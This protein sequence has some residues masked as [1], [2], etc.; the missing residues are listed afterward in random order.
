MV[1]CWTSFL[2]DGSNQ[3]TDNYGGTLKNRARLPLAVA[4]EVARVWG[5]KRVGYKIS[6]HFL[7]HAMSDTN[8]RETFAYLAQ[9]LGRLGIGYI[10]LVEPIGGR[11]GQIQP[12]MQM[13]PLI[14]KKFDGT[15]I[16][17]GGYDLKS[18]TEAIESGLADLIAFG[19]LFLANPDLP[20]RFG[21]NTSLNREDISTFYSGEEKGY[22]DY[23]SLGS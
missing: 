8:P 23:P 17:N 9:E 4:E 14:R 6:P 15:L 21:K 12:E 7:N 13:A 5:P 16:L 18:S 19:V 2:R 1:T 11:L 3:R 20:E 10:H 22:T